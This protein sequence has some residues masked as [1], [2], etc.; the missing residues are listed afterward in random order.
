MAPGEGFIRSV[1]SP[2]QIEVNQ[3]SAYSTKNTAMNIK[4]HVVPTDAQ[5]TCLP[6]FINYHHFIIEG[7]IPKA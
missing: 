4:N 3:N 2:A 7:A 5:S 1:K 6:L